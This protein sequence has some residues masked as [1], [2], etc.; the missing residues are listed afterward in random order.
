MGDSTEQPKHVLRCYARPS[1]RTRWDQPGPWLTGCQPRDWR[2]G[3]EW[4]QTTNDRS[5]PL[6]LPTSTRLIISLA[7][8]QLSNIHIT[9]HVWQKCRITYHNWSVFVYWNGEYT[10]H[11]SKLLHCCISVACSSMSQAVSCFLSSVWSHKNH[12]VDNPLSWWIVN[13]KNMSQNGNLPQRYGC[14]LPKKGKP[15]PGN[16]GGDPFLGWWVKWTF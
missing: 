12:L 11:I 6:S 16:S 15:P 4:C 7:T 10:K 14:Q 5:K 3:G 8:V 13:L 9:E 1:S 2:G